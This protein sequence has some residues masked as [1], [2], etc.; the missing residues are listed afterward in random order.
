MLFHSIPPLL[1]ITCSLLLTSAYASETLLFSPVPG[2]PERKGA[3]DQTEADQ[4]WEML[5]L[6]YFGER[7]IVEGEQQKVVHLD[8]PTRTE[9]DAFVPVSIATSQPP[10]VAPIRKVYLIV[11]IN[12]IPI[13]G[14]FS[15]TRQRPLENIATRVRVNGYSY[16]R[17]VVET[18][19][20]E[21]YMAKELVKSRGVA[22]AAPPITSPEEAAQN[23]GKMRFRLLRPQQPG[24]SGAVQLMISHP[25]ATGLQKDQVSLLYIPEHYV[26]E[27]EVTFNDELLMHAE[28]TYSIS[29]NPSFRFSFDPQARGILKARMLDTRDNVFF[30]S[31]EIEPTPARIH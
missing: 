6:R 9:D 24:E 31:S 16:V 25:N 23:L 3:F 2:D 14:V 12:P 27:I 10:G 19:D 1:V 28:T 20:G 29:E 30:L 7:A 21:L 4:R 18:T 11:D 13:A 8:V 5:S 17:A 15:M 22:C 26:K